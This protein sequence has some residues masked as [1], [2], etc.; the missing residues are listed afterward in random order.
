MILQ[1]K[2]WWIGREATTLR[3]WTIDEKIRTLTELQGKRSGKRKAQAGRTRSNTFWEEV[4]LP[5]LNAS[6][7][8]PVLEPAGLVGCKLLAIIQVLSQMLSLG[9]VQFLVLGSVEPAYV[10]G[11][12]AEVS[13]VVWLGRIELPTTHAP[14]RI[15]TSVKHQYMWREFEYLARRRATTV[16]RTGVDPCR[17]IPPNAKWVCRCPKFTRRST[18]ISLT[19]LC[20]RSI[21]EEV[22]ESRDRRCGRGWRAQSCGAL[23]H[24]QPAQSYYPC[25]LD[26]PSSLITGDQIFWTPKVARPAWWVMITA[27]IT[28]CSRCINSHEGRYELLALQF[29]L[30]KAL[31]VHMLHCHVYVYTH[32]RIGLVP[33]KHNKDI[34]CLIWMS[35]HISWFMRDLGKDGLRLN[36]FYQDWWCI[37][38]IA[39]Y[40]SYWWEWLG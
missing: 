32:Q 1:N 35:L 19:L 13:A 31:D 27:Q 2:E 6:I 37:N 17:Q 16:S 23:V 21:S 22:R 5:R 7:A 11:N 24:P 26:Q 34:A 8:S 40:W 3:A 12:G 9:V 20:I 4:G 30:F 10:F 33:T 18:D 14:C 28:V 36:V 38:Y 39:S 29:E 25:L 15:H